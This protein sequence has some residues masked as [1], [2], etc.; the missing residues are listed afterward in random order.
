MIRPF[1]S[2]LDI[3][4]PFLFYAVPDTNAGGPYTVFTDRFWDWR[5]H[6]YPSGVGTVPGTFKVYFGQTP[7]PAVTPMQGTPDQWENGIDYDTWLAGGYPATAF[8]ACTPVTQ[9]KLRQQQTLIAYQAQNAS[10][11]E[12]QSFQVNPAAGLL[13]QVQSLQANPLT[14]PLAQ[15]QA[16]AVNPA[17]G[18]LAQAQAIAVNPAAGLLA[19]AQAI[20]VNRAAGLLSQAQAIATNPTAGLLAQAQ[21]IAF[22][23]AQG[24]LDQSQIIQAFPAGGELD[25]A[26]RV[27]A[28]PAGGELDQA[29]IVQA[30]PAGGELDQKQTLTVTPT[31]SAPV[32]IQVHF[33][34]AQ[35]LHVPLVVSTPTATT[36]GSFLWLCVYDDNNGHTVSTPSGWTAGK[37]ATDSVG[38]MWTFYRYNSPSITSFTVAQGIVNANIRLYFVELGPVLTSGATDLSSGASGN[39]VAPWIAGPIGPTGHANEFC[40]ACYATPTANSNIGISG[41]NWWQS[42]TSIDIHPISLVIEASISNM[43][44]TFDIRG[45]FGSTPLVWS[46]TIQSFTY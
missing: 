21:A 44:T 24:E 43:V 7:G 31:F 27:Q 40:L 6:W 14:S 35:A 17:A 29:Q 41:G 22:N 32:V 2:R 1:P 5:E 20:A 23:P 28:F 18:L 34:N 45:G 16:I 39:S 37:T 3:E 26:Q 11:D 38:K 30:F 12:V 42:G 15:A 46:G 33:Q 8:P 13:A 4:V 36:A 25:Q 10:W 19:Q 9:A